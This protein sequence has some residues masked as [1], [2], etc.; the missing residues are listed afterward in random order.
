[1]ASF[2]PYDGFSGGLFVASALRPHGP[3]VRNAAPLAPIVRGPRSTAKRRPAYV[4]SAVDPDGQSSEIRFRCSFD[5]RQLHGCPKR[6]SQR[7]AVG[8]HVLRVQAFDG[9]GGAS[10]VTRVAVIV[11][12][13]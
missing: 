8:R 2:A 3:V 6:Y 1:M 7:L 12:R 5:R 13:R 10:E 9:D 11:R 4:F